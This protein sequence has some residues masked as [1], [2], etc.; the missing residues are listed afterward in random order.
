[1][2]EFLVALFAGAASDEVSRAGFISGC[3]EHRTSP[4]VIEEH[5][6][7]PL[8][9]MMLGTSRTVRAGRAVSFEFLEI[10]VKDRKLTYTA[11]V[12]GQTT[13]FAAAKVTDSEVVFENP[14]HDF[15]QRIIYRRTPNGLFARIEGTDNGRPRARDFPYQRVSCD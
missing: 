12:N 15:P 2:I 3:W 9:G 1:M 5:W 4:T 8:G 14:A 7:K 10:S 13:P 6:N 11:R